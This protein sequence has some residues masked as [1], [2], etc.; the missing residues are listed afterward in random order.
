MSLILLH[1]LSDAW[2]VGRCK[3]DPRM[4]TLPGV[5]AIIRAPTL[6]ACMN[7]LRVALILLSAPVHVRET[8]N[9]AQTFV[10]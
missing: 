2:R 6:G 10:T 9:L 3:Q 5:M 4:V 8:L 7:S 1:P